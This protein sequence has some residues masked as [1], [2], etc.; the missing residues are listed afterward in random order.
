MPTTTVLTADAAA[1]R[2]TTDTLAPTA[3]VVVRG[4]RFVPLAVLR[5]AVD[6]P[7]W[8]F[9]RAVRELADA[10]HGWLRVDWA[11]T[12]ADDAAS[13]RHHGTDFHL[14]TVDGWCR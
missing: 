6:L 5:A 7:P 12:A 1:V 13:V 4:Q 3:S 11:S 8:R 9:D 14:F 2:D 10:F